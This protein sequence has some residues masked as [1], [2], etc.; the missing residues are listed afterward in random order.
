MTQEGIFVGELIGSAVLILFGAGVRGAVTLDCSKAKGA[1]RVLIARF[2]TSSDEDEALPTLERPCDQPR[3]RTRPVHHPL[4]APG[5]REGDPAPELC[6]DTD[7]ATTD[8][9]GAHGPCAQ[10]SLLTL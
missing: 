8:R 5:P 6:L 10:R 2:R 1:G 3:P 9:R 4:P 7:G